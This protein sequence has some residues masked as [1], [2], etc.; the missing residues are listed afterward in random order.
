MVYT[1][2]GAFWCPNIPPDQAAAGSERIG[3]VSSQSAQQRPP[4]AADPAPPQG[5][6]SHPRQPLHLD[7]GRRQGR[8]LL[9]LAPQAARIGTSSE[10]KFRRA[11]LN[12]PSATASIWGLGNVAF[13]VLQRQCEPQTGSPLCAGQLQR[14]TIQFSR[15]L[16]SSGNTRSA[17]FCKPALLHAIAQRP[18]P[19]G[20]LFL[21]SDVAA[22]IEPM[23]A[24]SE[25]CGAFDRP[26]TDPRPWR[27]D[28][29]AAVASEREQHVLSQGQPVY[30][31][32]LPA[33]NAAL[34]PSPGWR[35]LPRP[36]HNRAISAA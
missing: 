27:N 13:P 17:V 5:L 7:I 32:A 8:F 4:A 34:R 25:A 36:T 18:R 9:A 35:R 24:L 20:E 33:H 29:S 11:S 15:S 23:V 28:Q 31:G 16:V 21:Q 1:P 30:R 6:F 26:R 12:A 3:A 19:G 10:S 14:V 2:A 22:V